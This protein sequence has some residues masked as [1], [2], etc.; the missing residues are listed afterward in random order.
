MKKILVIATVLLS[1]QLSFAQS[2]EFKADALSYA[3]TIGIKS[4]M[5]PIKEQFLPAI[6][7]TNVNTFNIEFDNV[8]NDFVLGFSKIIT[9][10]YQ[11]ADVKKALKEYE[12]TKNFV[13]LP[14]LDNDAE[15]NIQVQQLQS[16]MMSD[17]QTVIVK[18]ADS[19]KLNLE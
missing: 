4:Q 17:I 3:Q 10:N 11:E 2:E 5:E 19:T 8:V 13:S 18:N 12:T 7:E 1:M 9:D 14:A 15:I 16:K 6:L